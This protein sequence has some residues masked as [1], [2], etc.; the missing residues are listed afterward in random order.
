MTILQTNPIRLKGPWVD[1]Y[2]LDEHTISSRFVGF[3]DVGD[4][5]FNTK[6]TVMGE[7]L[8]RLKYRENQDYLQP[9]AGTTALFL[10]HMNW[11]LDCIIPVPPSRQRTIQPVI[12]L[13]EIIGHGLSLP[14]K[15]TAMSKVR[16]TPELKNVYT[17]AE[18]LRVLTG[19]YML[20]ER[21]DGQVVLL[22]DD[23]YRS[24]ATLEALSRL[25]YRHQVGAIYVL[26][27]TKTR[28]KL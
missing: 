24:G 1:G 2:A 18:R 16:T 17:Y 27:L 14:V 26:T 22:F 7:A 25:L 8:H 11:P 12:E 28:K 20:N 13:A 3:D 6:R 9:L 10:N 21:L 23:L 4:P 15:S 5:V 19:V